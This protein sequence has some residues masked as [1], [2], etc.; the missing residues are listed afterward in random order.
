LLQGEH[1]ERLDL[2]EIVRS[3]FEPAAANT[4]AVPWRSHTLGRPVFDQSSQES[5]EVGKGGL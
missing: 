1:V 3:C 5:I 2:P 4:L